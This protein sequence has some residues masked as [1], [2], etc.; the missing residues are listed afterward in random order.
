MIYILC[1]VDVKTGGTELLHQLAFQL[2]SSSSNVR[3]KIAY[4]GKD[5][6]IEPVKEFKK[7]IATN[8]IKESEIAESEKNVFI[9]HAIFDKSLSNTEKNYIYLNKYDCFI[10]QTP[11]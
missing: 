2:N 6:Q 11:K 5:T 3:A 10:L 7:Y 1:P 8:W 4:Y 9:F